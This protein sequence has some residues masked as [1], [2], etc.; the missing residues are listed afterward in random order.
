[1]K[2]SSLGYLIKEGLRNIK[3]NSFM[4]IASI[5]VLV[6]CLLLSGSAYLVF[7]NVNEGFKWAT[8]QNTAIVWAKADAT[9]EDLEALKN[10]L[11][12][13]DNVNKETIK[14]ISKEDILK[15]HADILGDATYKSLQG[16]NNPM[17]DAYEITFL[18]LEQFDQTIT[19]IR[20][21]KTIDSV[22]EYSQVA[23]VLNN[24]KNAVFSI[25]GWIVLMLLLVSLFIISNT[26]KLTVYSRRLE[27]SIMKSVGATKS[28]IRLPFTV[29]GMVIGLFSGLLSY[30][31]TYFVYTRLLT[32]VNIGMIEFSP[33]TITGMLGFLPVWAELLIG[34]VVLGTITGMIGSAISINR[35]LKEES[36]VNID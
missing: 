26:I 13:I 11:M 4:S 23:S 20:N 34:F 1:M 17:L 6:S 32:S 19:T 36:G 29:E 15:D 27:I 28:F 35:Y 31:V 16:Q 10:Q 8:S 9:K 7:V 24:I 2:L 14:F 33:L 21:L 5:L 25:G 22:S 12:S 30:G 3:Q 18:K